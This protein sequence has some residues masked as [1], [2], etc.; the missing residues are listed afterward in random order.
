MS[1]NKELNSQNDL[2]LSNL[3]SMEDLVLPKKVSSDLDLSSLKSV[4]DLVLSKKVGSDLNLSNLEG[5]TNLELPQLDNLDKMT[6]EDLKKL[7]DEIFNNSTK[8]E[9]IGRKK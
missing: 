9:N 5:L 4:E 2:N 8:S 3:K 1:N 6:A 7:R